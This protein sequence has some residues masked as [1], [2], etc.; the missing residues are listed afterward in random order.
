MITIGEHIN[1][2]FDRVEDKARYKDLNVHDFVFELRNEIIWNGKNE[3]GGLPVSCLIFPPKSIWIFNSNVANHSVV[4]G[5]KLQIWECD[6]DVSSMTS[7]NC[8]LPNIVENL[9]ASI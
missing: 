6:V 2:L 3:Y 4:W 5:E 7:P 9:Q 1:I 8:T